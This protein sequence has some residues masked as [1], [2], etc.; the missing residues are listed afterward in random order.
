[1]AQPLKAKLTTKNI[2]G[3]SC[4]PSIQ[5]FDRGVLLFLLGN[6][7]VSNVEPMFYTKTKK[8]TLCP[9]FSVESRFGR[10]NMEYVCMGEVL[11]P[12]IW[13]AHNPQPH[14]YVKPEVSSPTVLSNRR[15]SCHVWP[16]R[17]PSL[18]LWGFSVPVPRLYLVGDATAVCWALVFSLFGVLSSSH[19]M[20]IKLNILEDQPRKLLAFLTCDSASACEVLHMVHTQ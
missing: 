14:M 4:P 1:M 19:L 13:S 9:L 6:Y 11:H 8:Q 20:H 7:C 16:L 18:Q 10:C 17:M 12:I 15:V 3:W 5:S 2:K